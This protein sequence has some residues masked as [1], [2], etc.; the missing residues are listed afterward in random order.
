MNGATLRRACLRSLATH[1]P[2]ADQLLKCQPRSFATVPRLSIATGAHLI[3]FERVDA[4]QPYVTAA[5]QKIIAILGSG[6]AAKFIL[7]K[8][9]KAWHQQK[10]RDQRAKHHL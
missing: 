6:G 9:R 5:D 4:M 3:G 7:S 2:F 1:L 8:R 10:C